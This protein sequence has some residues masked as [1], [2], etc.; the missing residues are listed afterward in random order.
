MYYGKPEN[1]R[2]PYARCP[3][4]PPTV[5]RTTY[6]Y[7]DEEPLKERVLVGA[8]LCVGGLVLAAALDV[9]ATWWGAR[10]IL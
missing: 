10:M 9:V 2:N 8:V 6:T 3:G 7:S 5:T 1:K 4:D